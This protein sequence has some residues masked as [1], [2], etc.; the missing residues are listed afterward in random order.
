MIAII[1]SIAAVIVAVF[2]FFK[3]MR[4]HSQTINNSK[5]IRFN[6]IEL[7]NL[8][9][10]VRLNL[11]EIQNLYEITPKADRKGNEIILTFEGERIYIT[12]NGNKKK[13]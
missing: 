1:L 2:A 8:K 9:K 12:E 10:D 3:S 7:A 11:E 13:K 6:Q 4:P 5:D